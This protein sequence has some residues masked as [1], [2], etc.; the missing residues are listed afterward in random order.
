[1]FF[2]FRTTEEIQSGEL[3]WP[4]WT[5]LIVVAIGF[6]GEK[7]NKVIYHKLSSICKFSGGIVFMYIQCKVYLQICRK[8]RAYNRTI[9][10]QV[11]RILK[12]HSCRWLSVCFQDLPLDV[13]KKERK[14]ILNARKPG[15]EFQAY[16]SDPELG[17]IEVKVNKYLNKLFKSKHKLL[18][19]I[20]LLRI[21][22]AITSNV[23]GQGLLVY[24]FICLYLK[25]C[26]LLGVLWISLT[27]RGK[28]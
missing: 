26:F 3:Q 20:Y 28:V 8:W 6:T 15:K 16:L 9:V 12:W 13:I 19:I 25:G 7:I 17:L 22:C 23:L 10:V 27:I 11:K 5:K 14:K 2:I 4:F 18:S 24:W 1:M 21:M